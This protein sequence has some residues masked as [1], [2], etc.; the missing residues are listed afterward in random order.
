MFFFRS[1]EEVEVVFHMLEGLGVPTEE[2][3]RAEPSD[4]EVGRQFGVETNG[5]SD[6]R[7]VAAGS[8]GSNVLSPRFFCCLLL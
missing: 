5:C 2:K 4:F 6:R 3:R 1:A 7:R 8:G